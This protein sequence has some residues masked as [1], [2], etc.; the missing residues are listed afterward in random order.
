MTGFGTGIEFRHGD[1]EGDCMRHVEAAERPAR[2]A[3]FR[4][5]VDAWQ[6]LAYGHH[7]IESAAVA[8][9]ARDWREHF[10]APTAHGPAPQA[11]PA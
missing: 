8:A 3:Y 2:K 1:T 9:L 6:S 10:A 11:Q 5:L 7:V 4:R